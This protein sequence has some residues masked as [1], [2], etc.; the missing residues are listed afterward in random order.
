MHMHLIPVIRQI[1]QNVARHLSAE[2]IESVCRQEGHR[3]RER[4]LGP[5][6]TLHAFLLQIL[7]GNTAC[8][9]VSRLLNA[10]FSA[11]AY[12]QAR[13]RLPL[14]VFERLLERTTQAAQTGA[15]D[16]RWR[17]HRTFLTDGSSFSMPDTPALQRH[18]GQSGKQRA[19]C[20][21][22][23]AHLLA[24]FDAGRG[25]LLK[26]QA[27]PLR[28]SDLSHV[29]SLHNAL[30]PDDVL[31]A[32]RGFS[33]Y[34][35]LGLL[36][37]RNIHALFRVHQRQ[38]I[39]FRRDR[40]LSGKRPRGTTALYA[41]SRLVRKLARF[42]QI[43][44]YTRPVARPQWIRAADYAAL[45]ETL[46]VRELRYWTKYRG[47]RTRCV[48]LVTT[49]VD[50]EAYPHDELATLYGRRWEVET[51]LNHLKTTMGLN[52][53]RCES[54]AGVL[55]ELMMFALVYNLVRLVMSAAAENQGIDV[56]RISFIDA[57]RW[58]A[59]ARAGDLLPV[60]QIVPHRP[61]RVEP[62]AIKRRPKQYNLLMRP[63]HE[64]RK[65]LL[66]NSVAA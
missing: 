24:L 10:A 54:L 63:R 41:K 21:F 50:P 9:H 48:T 55:K 61:H 15:D 13:C 2:T 18:F 52:V 8:T 36:F 45:P 20:G 6:V 1:K 42:D 64:L 17:G 59:Q 62:R 23:V 32:D 27:L 26:V 65:A 37:R 40:R 58:L 25:L 34:V 47:Y 53:L 35:H 29:Q 46:Q 51:N 28:T 3:W 5:V 43:V 30:S 19:G 33:S 60:L 44:E 38:L 66:E 7:H 12:C 16:G 49:L 4:T 14:V 57:L 39:S 56:R 22:P 11:G 31:V